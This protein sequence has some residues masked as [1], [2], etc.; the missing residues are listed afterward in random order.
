M[1]ESPEIRP[2]APQPEPEP[3]KSRPILKLFLF[4]LVLCFGAGLFGWHEVRTFLDTAPETPGKS[5]LAP[6]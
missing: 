6:D 4:L 5:N 1:S 2:D 3:K